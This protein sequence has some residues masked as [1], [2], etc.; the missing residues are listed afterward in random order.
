MTAGAYVLYGL[1]LFMF[2]ATGFLAAVSLGAWLLTHD[3][4]EDEWP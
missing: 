4:R 2:F 1:T 3:A